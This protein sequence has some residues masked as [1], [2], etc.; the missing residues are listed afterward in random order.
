MLHKMFSGN[1]NTLTG[2]SPE[3]NQNAYTSVHTYS[4]TQAVGTYKYK[5]MCVY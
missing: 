5:Y 2:I 1:A 4:M 3:G